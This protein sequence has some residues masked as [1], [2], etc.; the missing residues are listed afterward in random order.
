LLRATPHRHLALLRATT[1]RVAL[2]LQHRLVAQYDSLQ[3]VELEQRSLIEKL[4]NREV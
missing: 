4:Q 3:K 2:P 1:P